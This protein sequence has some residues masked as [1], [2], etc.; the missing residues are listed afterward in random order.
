MKEEEKKLTKLTTVSR[1]FRDKV[2]ENSPYE[3][4]DGLDEVNVNNITPL[5]NAIQAL[6]IKNMYTLQ[7]IKWKEELKPDPLDFP[8]PSLA[9]VKKS[10][11]ASLK[12]VKKSPKPRTK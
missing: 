2:L 11:P 4:Y 3:S 6:G 8:S 7:G 5:L 10:F 12:N 1:A 9:I